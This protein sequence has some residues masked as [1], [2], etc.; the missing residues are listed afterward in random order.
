MDKI[1]KKYLELSKQLETIINIIPGLL[2]CKD[3]NDIITLANQQYA[4]LLKKNKKDILGKTTYD[5]FS[6]EHAEAF[7]K[8]DKEII[9]TGKAKLN[10]EVKGDFPNGKGYFLTSKVPLIDDKGKIN[11]IVGLSIDITERK[12]MEEKLRYS[13]EMFSKAFHTNFL[14]NSITEYETG[15]LV[16]VSELALNNLGMTKEEVIGKSPTELGLWPE[17]QD[18]EKDILKILEEKG[19]VNNMPI[20]TRTADGDIRHSLMSINKITINDKLYHLN[21]VLDITDRV[22]MENELKESEEKYKKA[23]EHENFYK[24][25]FAHD[26]NNILQSMMLSLE[27]S[28]IKLGKLE[29]VKETKDILKEIKEQINRGANLVENVNRF[30]ELDKLNIKLN[31][32]DVIGVLEKSINI[33]KKISK[34]KVEISITKTYNNPI[35]LADEFLFDVFE[36]I[37]INAIKHNKNEIVKIDIHILKI[38]QNQDHLLKMEFKDNGRG[39]NVA[40]IDSLFSRV[41]YCK[42]RSVSGMG[43][44]LTLVKRILNNYNA[45]I[46]V[47]NNDSNEISKGATFI[48]TFPLILV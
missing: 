37:L 8:V 11:G 35:I 12:K 22:K 40:I 47:K 44:G 16:E 10:Y 5:L 36:N 4:N 34:K 46:Q 2:Y 1:K 20:Q 48:L 45:E 26:M 14:V 17:G 18:L 25:L 19:T 6:K 31:N 30:S 42:D 33:A 3:K 28:E 38:S 9:K 32:I 41:I 29:N 43:F 27:L 7:H 23:Y 21:M 13:E 15:R 24:D 39:I